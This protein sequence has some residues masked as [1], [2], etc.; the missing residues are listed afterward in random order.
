[1][2]ADKEELVTILVCYL[3]GNREA[4]IVQKS[5]FTRVLIGGAQ[6]FSYVT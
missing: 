1:M 4:S 2:V 3:K 6:L 5:L